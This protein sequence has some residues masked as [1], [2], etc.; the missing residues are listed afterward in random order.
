MKRILPLFLSLILV[1]TCFIVPASA[2]ENDVLF[3]VLDLGPS[4]N[5]TNFSSTTG[6]SLNITYK[7]PFKVSYNYLD[8]V[9]SVS[10]TNF[11][12]PSSF[13]V[14]RLGSDTYRAYGHISGNNTDS[15]NFTLTYSATSN[16]Q[17]K[18]E[19]ISFNISLGSK[20]FIHTGLIGILYASS[21]SDSG[22]YT[23]QSPEDSYT[24]EL[25]PTVEGFPNNCSGTIYVSNWQGYDYIDFAINFYG[26]K[27]DFINA[28][29]GD[30][31]V[32]YDVSYLTNQ[33]APDDSNAEIEG[34]TSLDT[35]YVFN[36]RVFL[37]DID[38]TST[39]YLT[40]YFTGNINGSGSF[41]TEHITGYV[42]SGVNSR[43][44]LIL[45]DLKN[46]FSN[47]FDSRLDQEQS[48]NE[49]QES[50]TDQSNRLEY[51]DA[52][53][54]GFEKPF[55]THDVFNADPIVGSSSF[56]LL[57]TGLNSVLS[58]HIL[59]Q[60]FTIALIL[61]LAGFILYGKK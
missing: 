5:G 2:S 3:N 7:L 4:S 13:K 61:G 38:R 58:N 23:M 34:I 10:D 21:G 47:L 59:L 41:T 18:I 39:E 43:F 54:K 57:A 15:V 32:S 45:S 33:I 48:A 8:I 49:F 27:L 31:S 28:Y 25:L 52:E 17:R 19:I 12:L 11:S 53:I 14:V 51:S 56:N 20:S 42:E 24:F 37:D 46:F 44:G 22:S 50:I 29:I 9:F 35:W 26:A 60:V 1:F 6:K 36:V 55:L 16:V 30:Q 40:V